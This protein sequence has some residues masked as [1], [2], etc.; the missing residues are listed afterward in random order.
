MR[1][2]LRPETRRARLVRILGGAAIILAAS[3]L[4][5]A[6]RR[7]IPHPPVATDSVPPRPDAALADLARGLA[8]FDDLAARAAASGSSDGFSERQDRL[9]AERRAERRAF[10]ASTPEGQAGETRLHFEDPALAGARPGAAPSFGRP[11]GR[12]AEIGRAELEA[13]LA[14][15]APVPVPLAELAAGTS[16]GERP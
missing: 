4:L 6:P 13:V 12:W 1:R 16:S 10:V 8:R 11:A 5:R 2:P 7:A 15:R 3:G 9:A 14:G